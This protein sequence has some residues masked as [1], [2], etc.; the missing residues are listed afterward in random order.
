MR[1]LSWW[2]HKNM[3]YYD[4]V[5]NLY[6]DHNP[7]LLV[8]RDCG[9]VEAVLFFDKQWELRLNHF[10]VHNWD[11]E[12]VLYYNTCKEAKAAAEVLVRMGEVDEQT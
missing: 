5:P 4:Y 11:E 6:A 8:D 7:Y 1:K 12:E 9:W 3:R 2:S 10:G